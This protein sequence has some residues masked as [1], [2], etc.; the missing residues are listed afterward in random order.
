MLVKIILCMIFV[1]SA[2]KLFIEGLSE[3]IHFLIFA[4]IQFI[5]PEFIW[6]HLQ[7]VVQFRINRNLCDNYLLLG[8]FG[9]FFEKMFFRF[10]PKCTFHITFFLMIIYEIFS[11]SLCC[12]SVHLCWLS[13]PLCW[14]SVPLCWFSV[15]LSWF[16]VPLVFSAFVFENG[17]RGTGRPLV[18]NSLLVYNTHQ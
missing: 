12:F 8:Q 17:I 6:N 4:K 18:V 15:P 1:I 11:V 3:N 5:L 13:G 14:F 16:S 10:I 9:W 2:G 7:N